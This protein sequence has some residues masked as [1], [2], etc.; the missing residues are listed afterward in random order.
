MPAFKDV[1]GQRFGRLIAVSSETR[2][3]GKSTRRMWLCICDCG[4][5]VEVGSGHLLNNHIQSCGCLKSELL[6]AARTKHGASGRN[7][8]ETTVWPEYRVWKAMKARCLNPNDPA[9]FKYGAR[10]ITIADRWV[11]SFSNFI[12]DMGRRPRPRLTLERI[13]NDGPYAPENCRWAT[14][15][16]QAANRRPRSCWKLTK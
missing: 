9:Y 11:H 15:K 3:S 12:E 4:G 13:N 1:S 14:Y 2:P 16:E 5:T 10:G 7:F 6:R 8:D